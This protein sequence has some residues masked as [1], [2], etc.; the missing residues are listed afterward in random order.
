MKWI[1]V[2]NKL[3][4]IGKDVLTY[5]GENMLVEYLLNDEDVLTWSCSPFEEIT[6]WMSLPEPPKR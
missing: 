5:D 3:P 1:S 4:K 2:E 6:H